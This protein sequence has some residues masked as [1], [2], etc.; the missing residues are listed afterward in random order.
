MISE[1][2][3]NVMT[4]QIEHEFFSAYLYLAMAEY[5]ESESLSGFAQWMRIQSKEELEHGMKFFDY[6]VERGARVSLRA[7]PQPQ[8]GWQ[9]PLDVFE[10]AYE[11]EQKVTSLIN[12]IYEIAVKE[13]DYASQ[14]MLHWFIDEQVEEEKNTSEIATRLRMAGENKG[15]L[16]NIDH[17]IGKRED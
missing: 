14:V 12:S 5:F 7:I 15:A 16:L 9:S 1:A 3:V 10:H 13:K 2:V 8:G 17:H 6:L 11:H 4:D